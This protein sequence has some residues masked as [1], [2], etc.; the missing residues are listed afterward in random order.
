MHRRVSHWLSQ[1]FIYGLASL[2][3]DSLQFSYQE[4]APG[5]ETSPRLWRD[6][7]LGKALLNMSH[8]TI[9]RIINQYPMESLSKPTLLLAAF[10]KALESSDEKEVAY[11]QQTCVEFHYM[12]VSTLTSYAKALATL[13][14]VFNEVNSTLRQ[15]AEAATE[16]KRRGILLWKFAHSPMLQHHLEGLKKC[17]WL[18]LPDRESVIFYQAYFAFGD[19]LDERDVDRDVDEDLR[20][21]MGN[22]RFPPIDSTLLKWI[23]LQ[24]SYFEAIHQL[25]HH[26]RR[27]E[28]QVPDVQISL[29]AV[30]TPFVRMEPWELTL[31]KLVVSPSSDQ[32]TSASPFDADAAVVLIKG[33]RHSSAKTERDPGSSLGKLPHN[34]FYGNVHCD[35]AL[36]SLMKYN[37]VLNPTW[38]TL[39]N[40]QGII[41]V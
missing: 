23:R 39:N 28:N 33:I 9:V 29:L 37:D 41:E 24:V 19:S 16:V 34:P 38:G 8:G 4:Y 26:C 7:V 22:D 40:L 13:H 18:H 21:L 27:L 36:A 30:K 15:K 17:G 2:T 6:F 12:F 25:S 14:V 1:G 3:P 32:L 35:A 10:K 20:Y 31:Q 5:P 11:N